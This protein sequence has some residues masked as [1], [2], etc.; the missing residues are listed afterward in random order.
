MTK[1]KALAILILAGT[2]LNPS[3]V[4]AD[5]A[6]LQTRFKQKQQ[7]FVKKQILKKLRAPREDQTS[8]DSDFETVSGEDESGAELQARDEA[9]IMYRNLRR[10]M[11][12]NH[13]QAVRLLERTGYHLD[14]IQRL[15]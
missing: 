3:S 6:N 13:A 7:Q 15:P 1:L 4:T 8:S 9:N 5:T 11:G 10:A 12:F 14:T 2:V